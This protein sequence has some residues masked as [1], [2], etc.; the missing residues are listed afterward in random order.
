MEVP[1]TD[2]NTSAH[3]DSPAV[4]S[5]ADALDRIAELAAEM[6]EQRRAREVARA[7]YQH[8][9]WAQVGAALGV[10]A[11]S[12]HRP[13]AGGLSTHPDGPAERCP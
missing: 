4:T 2:D 6:L 3:P 12:A 8:A 13:V 10:T 5:P 1:L 7:G 9:I 11:Q